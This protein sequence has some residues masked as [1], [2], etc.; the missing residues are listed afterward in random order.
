M[1]FV[2]VV[3]NAQLFVNPRL[4]MDW[5][6]GLIGY[7]RVGFEGLKAAYRVIFWFVPRLTYGSTFGGND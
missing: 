6:A 2:N 4:T 1:S 3:C 7:L 5:I